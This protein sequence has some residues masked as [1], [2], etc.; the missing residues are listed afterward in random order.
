VRSLEFNAVGFAYPS[1]PGTLALENFTLRV[2]QG[3]RVALVGP[4]GA[5]KTTVFRVAAAVLRPAARRGA[6]RRRRCA[7]H[8]SDRAAPAWSPSCRRS[9]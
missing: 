8:G 9:R 3:E 4:S 1:R 2:A 7:Q 6:D 5:G